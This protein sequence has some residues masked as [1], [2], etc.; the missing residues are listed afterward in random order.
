[1]S[2]FNQ[3]LQSNNL[4]LQEI[5]NTINAL[6][7]AGVQLPALDNEGAAADL[8]MGKELINSQGE[9]ITGVFTLEEE[10]TTQDDLIAQLQNAVDNLPDAGTGN[11][12][13]DTCTVEISLDTIS[14]QD[15][16]IK[17][18]YTTADNNNN[19]FAALD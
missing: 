18:A 15:K 8:L 14:L 7:E 6:P 10:L 3:D 17:V 19:V 1:M 12:S 13:Y 5:L 9:K 4:T 2:K 16:I 11:V